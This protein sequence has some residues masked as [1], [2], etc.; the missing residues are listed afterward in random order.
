MRPCLVLLFDIPPEEK[1]RRNLVMQ[2]LVRWYAG[3]WYTD[4]GTQVLRY[5]GPHEFDHGPQTFSTS[6]TTL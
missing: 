2:T 6:R 1:L 5:K 3:S 4:T